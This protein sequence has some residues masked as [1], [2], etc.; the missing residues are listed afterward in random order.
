MK[1]AIDA[2]HGLHTKGKRCLKELDPKETREWVLNSR[3]VSQVVEHLERCGA[4]CI[5]LDDVTGKTDV[6]LKTRT[7]K[8]NAAKADYCVS[9]HHNAG[10][11][12]GAGGGPV[13]YVYNG[14]HSTQADKL[15]LYVYDGL[16][17]AVGKFGN[18][19]TP[20]AASNLHM[21]RETNM[22][23][24]LVE[25][26]F[27]DSPTDVPLILSEAWAAK[28]AEGIAHGIARAAGLTWVEPFAPYLAR[29]VA[30]ELNVR[31]GPGV[32]YP[33]ATTVK[34]GEVYTIVAEQYN[35]ATA[36][37]KLKSGAGWIS[38][39]YTDRLGKA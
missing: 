39:R 6:T 36:W 2:G 21:V 29:I 28:A 37:G 27:M 7:D 33:V 34:R 25:V 38:L 5:R 17:G 19:S 8:A 11:K 24:V 12:G 35:G 32:S 3:I 10:V 15:Q 22:P 26:G 31:Q 18:R 30:G 20:L 16:I 23:A 9:I 1:I 13:V 4:E 14:E